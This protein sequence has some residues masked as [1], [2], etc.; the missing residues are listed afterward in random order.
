MVAVCEFSEV[1]RLRYRLWESERRRDSL[2]RQLR[3]L[4]ASIG[5]RSTPRSLLEED[6]RRRE[7]GI[8]PAHYEIVPPPPAPAEPVV[9][10]V[11]DRRVAPLGEQYGGLR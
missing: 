9:L 8:P 3:E 1:R 7:Q 11:E 10:E 6:R 5:A 4:D 2:S